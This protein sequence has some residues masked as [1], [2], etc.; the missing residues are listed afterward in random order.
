MYDNVP[1]DWGEYYFSCPACGTRSHASEG[2]CGGC[3]AREEERDDEDEDAPVV[4]KPYTQEG[5]CGDYDED[6]IPF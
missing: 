4:S 2:S 5:Y 1:D 3:E 6:D